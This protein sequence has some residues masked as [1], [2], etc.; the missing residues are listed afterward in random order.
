M[1]TETELKLRL[2]PQ[3]LGRL[4]R[5]ALLRALSIGRP[6]IR[7]V[8][9]VYYDTP[10]L[11]LRRAE[12]ALRLRRVGG[13]WLQT[14][15][16][17]GSVQAGLHSREEWE[18]PVPGAALD[19]SALRNS[20][21]G[22]RLPSDVF[23]R[24]QPVFITEFTRTIRDLV[25]DGAQIE[26]AVDVG[27]VRAGQAV[28]PICEVELELKSGSVTTLFQV[29]RR[30]M[31]KLPLSLENISK[32]EHGYD[33]FSPQLRLPVKAI[34]PNIGADAS[35]RDAL[36]MMLTV[37]LQHWQANMAGLAQSDNPEFLHQIRVA[38]RR[39]R[40]ALS[41]AARWQRDHELQDLRAAF[42]ALSKQLGSARDWDVLV[43]ELLP[44]FG[45][46]P[47]NAGEYAAFQHY[48]ESKRAQAVA[49]AVAIL[50]SPAAQTLLLRLGAWISQSEKS[51]QEI[52]LDKFA[53]EMLKM[54]Y[55]DLEACG[56]VLPNGDDVALH[57]MR[58]E[59]KKL[60]YSIELMTGV[61]VRDRVVDVIARLQSLQETL[62]RLN[63]LS[64][65]KAL[66]LSWSQSEFTAPAGWVSTQLDGLAPAL[67]ARLSSLWQLWL[68][69]KPVFM[70]KSD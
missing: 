28:W 62:G 6:K 10:D 27:E 29:A 66:L 48:A 42:R 51:H 18:Q 58:I 69:E 45:D 19:T 55:A 15:K 34:A 30:L 50:Q 25:V 21:L 31:E 64:Q 2:A 61:L 36:Q 40:V 59:C 41:M 70:R 38:I 23:D 20:P 14:L 16:G 43:D 26:C 13:Q 47:G 4:R 49:D 12:M 9:S 33:L 46:Y 22:R 37:C 67:K 68:A 53:R 1:A 32:A 5:N 24:I 60:R 39:L 7:K 35:V 54:R 56:G 11:E 44:K 3:A 63:D 57:A 52:S 65:G 17:G 8:Y